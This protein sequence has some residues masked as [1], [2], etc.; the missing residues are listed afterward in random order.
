M[1]TGPR[2]YGRSSTKTRVAAGYDGLLA[3][4]P[5]GAAVGV[6]AVVG[7]GVHLRLEA[8][9]LEVLFAEVRLR[10]LCRGV[11]LGVL[12]GHKSSLASGGSRV[13][14]RIVARVP[15]QAISTLLGVP[16]SRALA[17]ACV[18]LASGAFL[19]DVTHVS[20]GFLRASTD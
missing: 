18:G 6:V 16:L 10:V 13:R 3:L 8:G 19:S 2:H 17:S 9:M 7:L 20:W 5:A 12:V 15:V 11:L 4:E 1:R 14:P